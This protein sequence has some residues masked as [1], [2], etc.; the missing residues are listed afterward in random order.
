MTV[1]ETSHILE[2]GLISIS[3]EDAATFLQGLITVDIKDILPTQYRLSGCCNNKGRLVASFYLFEYGG[4]YYLSLPLEN[5]PDTLD[6][7]QKYARFSKVELKEV[8]NDFVIFGILAE[9][10][11]EDFPKK[12]Y[13]CCQIG[14]AMVLRL[15]GNPVRF[16]LI[17][18]RSAL[19]S[20]SLSDMKSSNANSLWKQYNIL[21]GIPAIYPETVGLFTPQML[22]Y[23]QFIA[24]SYNK[25][26]YL[27][28]EIV[29][30]TANLGTVKKH[31][32]GFTV[33]A[34]V[35]QLPIVGEELNDEQNIQVGTILEVSPSSLPVKDGQPYLIYLSAVIQDA[36]LPMPI[37]W[38]G[39]ALT[40]VS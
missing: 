6:H 29:A 32:Y 3:G 35:N 14:T 10:S 21:T 36:A 24:I 13:D 39:K 23:D 22:N 30:R 34:E 25:G 4:S 38:Q 19:E 20:E 31:L 16:E 37:Y 28:Q 15:P 5:V 1:L 7:L 40:K 26:C 17:E 8:T 27:G 12:D 9:N 2:K 11:L 33:E 18:K